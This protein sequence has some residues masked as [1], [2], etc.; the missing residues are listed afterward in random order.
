[1][2]RIKFCLIYQK[3]KMENVIELKNEQK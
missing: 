1:M 3:A 2:E